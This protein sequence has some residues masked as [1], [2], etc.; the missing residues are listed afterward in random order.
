MEQFN[1]E[2]QRLRDERSGTDAEKNRIL[3]DALNAS[4]SAGELVKRSLTL[5]VHKLAVE[6]DSLKLPL[7]LANVEDALRAF[8]TRKREEYLAA[9]AE[10]RAMLEKLATDLGYGNP[11]RERHG[12]VL[13]DVE[14]RRLEEAA[15]NALGKANERLDHESAGVLMME[16]ERRIRESLK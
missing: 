14:R 12:F 4:A 9:E 7:K 10:R 3:S 6:M 5:Q 1:E 13:Q 11:S 8:W 16:A 2:V 15:R